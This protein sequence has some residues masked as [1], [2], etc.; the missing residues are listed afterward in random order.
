[1]PP[2][3]PARAANLNLIR[4]RIVHARARNIKLP[5]KSSSI[6]FHFSNFHESATHLLSTSQ[7]DPLT[8]TPHRLSMPPLLLTSLLLSLHPALHS[9]TINDFR[10]AVGRRP[11]QSEPISYPLRTGATA[12]SVDPRRNRPS[13]SLMT[14]AL[15]DPRGRPRKLSA[16][17]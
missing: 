16:L 13:R 8:H 4:A 12:H 2:S 11:G 6:K 5:L 15:P 17:T 7:T 3:A 14:S 9:H 10:T 1:M